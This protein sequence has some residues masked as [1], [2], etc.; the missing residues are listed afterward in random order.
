MFGNRRLDRRQVLAVQHLVAAAVPGL[1]PERITLVDDRGTLLARGGDTGESSG[2]MGAQADDYRQAYQARMKRVIEQ[3]L[4]RSLGSGRVHAEVSAEFDFD[5]IT[6]TQE[7]FDP[8][9]Q[10]VRSTQT[11]EE[12]SEAAERDDDDAVTVGNNLPNAGADTAA[13]GRASN[14][15]TTR[16]EETINYEISRTVRNHTRIGGQVERLSVA[17]LVDGRMVPNAAGE[18]VYTSLD[19]AELAE[20]ASLVR[21]AIGF[22]EARGDVVE[23][24]NMP[25]TVPPEFEVVDSWFDFT[26]HDLMRLIE[27][28]VLAIIGVL[29]IFLVGRPAVT[30]LLAPELA[31]AGGASIPASLPPGPATPALTGPG[32]GGALGSPGAGDLVEVDQVTGQVHSDLIKQAR[33]AIEQVPDDAAAVVRGWLQQG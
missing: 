21:S 15:N 5:Q 18:P 4:E 23:I 10:V 26:K 11:V 29:L 24:K 32:P 9:G 22:D 13:S 30:R 17:V 28:A 8:E 2:Q 12:E 1:K 6:T 33:D 14:E 27:I 25:F 31:A 16:S 20:M 7:T 19:E 3:L